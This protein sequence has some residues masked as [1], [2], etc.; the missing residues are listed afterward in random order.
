ME[1]LKGQKE[2]PN[3]DALKELVSSRA[4]LLKNRILS[5]LSHLFPETTF[6]GMAKSTHAEDGVCSS[7]GLSFFI[8]KMGMGLAPWHS[9]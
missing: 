5:R 8:Y 7:L 4:R 6:E 3:P 9:G 1:W 2:I